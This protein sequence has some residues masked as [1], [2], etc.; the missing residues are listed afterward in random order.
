MMSRATIAAVAVSMATACATRAVVPDAPSV[1]AEVPVT[2]ARSH[3]PGEYPDAM[4]LAARGADPLA[5]ALGVAGPFQGTRQEIVQVNEGGELPSKSIVTLV[6][7]G[8]LDDS[9]R[10]ERWKVTLGRSQSGT[11]AITQVQRSV[12]CR[13]G[14]DPDRYVA[15]PC[16]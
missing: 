10:G 16:P 12:R 9:L 6:R 8:L 5:I 11:W 15:G 7:D 13:R 14:G 2:G 3:A 4:A 1:S